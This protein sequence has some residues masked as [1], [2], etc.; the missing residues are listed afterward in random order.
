MWVR[1]DQGEVSG[2]TRREGE[3]G[4]SCTT[5]FPHKIHGGKT[6]EPEPRPPPPGHEKGVF[7]KANDRIY[8][9]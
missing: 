4:S 7:V 3:G 9:I 8:F 5:K 1:P 2:R 6:S